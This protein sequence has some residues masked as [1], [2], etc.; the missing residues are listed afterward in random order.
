MPASIVVVLAHPYP[1][2]SRA[3]R[4]MLDAIADV[5]GVELRSLYDLYPDFAIDVDA[6]QEALRRADV[7][8][9][10]CPIFWYSPPAL[11]HLWFEK[12]LEHGFAYGEGGTALAGKPLLW[13]TT[14]GTP[15]SAY[16]AGG[17]HGRP[18]VEFTHGV[19]QTARYCGLRWQ[20]PIVVH[21]EHDDAAAEAV[22]RGR[23]YRERLL[24][25]GRRVEAAE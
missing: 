24:D 21:A 18:F 6:E 22:A 13:V 15:P 7:V 9:W 10:Q 19:E 4:A 17:M 12:V 23:E 2:R 16:R 5:P 20:P 8:V 3:G 14:T 11:L 1:R 25:L